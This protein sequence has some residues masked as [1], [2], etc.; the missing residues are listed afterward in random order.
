MD[1]REGRDDG[2]GEKRGKRFAGRRASPLFISGPV[3][4][5]CGVE[6]PPPAQTQSRPLDQLQ[7][8]ALVVALGDWECR[9]GLVLFLSRPIC[10]WEEWRGMVRGTSLQASPG[11]GGPPPSSLDRHGPAIHLGCPLR[12]FLQASPRPL[13]KSPPAAAAGFPSLGR[14]GECKVGYKMTGSTVIPS[15]SQAVV[16]FG[17]KVADESRQI[18]VILSR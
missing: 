18:K 13:A 6:T 9:L 7:R 11:C 15:L 4:F 3:F 16:D 14:S 17:R 8:Q 5:P 2:R 10:G 12:L 1:K